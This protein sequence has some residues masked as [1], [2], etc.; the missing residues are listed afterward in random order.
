MSYRAVH[1]RAEFW[2]CASSLLADADALASLLS[3]IVVEA[4]MRPVG[5]PVKLTVA[6]EEAAWGAGAS[7]TQMLVDEPATIVIQPLEKSH[8]SIHG[9]VQRRHCYA[10]IFACSTLDQDL[11]ALNLAAYLGVKPW[12]MN[13]RLEDRTITRWRRMLRYIQWHLGY[14]FLRRPI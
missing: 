3:Y 5:P 6:D 7:V 8:A 10:D 12:Q 2:G 9:L 13:V 14:W 4:G 1:L 11:L